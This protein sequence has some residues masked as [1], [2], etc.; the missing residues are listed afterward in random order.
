MGAKL[1]VYPIPIYLI[2]TYN[3]DGKANV[4]TVG[5]GGVC[6]SNPP[7][8]SISVRK[9]THTYH[10]LIERE[11]FTANL[12]SEDFGNEVSYFGKVSGRNENKFEQ[13]GLT[14]VKSTFVDAPYIEEMLINLE[15][16][17][18]QIHEIGSHT[19]FIGQIVNAKI[20]SDLKEDG[21]P[22]IEQ[23]KPI[24][25]G[26]GN[27]HRYYRIGEVIIPKGQKN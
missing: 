24:V 7:C 23:L 22:I 26:V 15:C 11:A 25:Y 21:T 14:P 18:I 10:A 16:K 19:Q 1:M 8:I 13:T 4:M 27:D 17:I 6:C 2:A 20:N 5:W 9:A 12:P 3:A